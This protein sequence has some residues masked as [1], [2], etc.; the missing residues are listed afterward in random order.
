[1]KS[2][3]YNGTSVKDIVDAAGVPKGSF[4]NYF[5]SKQTFAAE[6]IEK[7]AEEGRQCSGLILNNVELP[8]L[9]R[10]EQYFSMGMSN[11]C[12][13]KFKIGCFLGNMC[14]E[15]SDS[16]DVLRE[17]VNESLS[18]ITSDIESVLKEAQDQGS[19]SADRDTLQLAQFLL[20]S[21]EGA[22]MRMKASKCS[23]PLQAFL[24]MLPFLYR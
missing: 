14:Q 22:L 1:M 8:P 17:K 9:E 6:A 16:C 2:S 11:A 23:E 10:L 13:G 5:D 12:E 19:L 18:M 7:V 3:G 4:Y 20:N 21:W 15:M 24:A